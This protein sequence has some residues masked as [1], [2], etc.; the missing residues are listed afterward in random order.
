MVPYAVSLWWPVTTALTWSQKL[1]SQHFTSCCCCHCCCCNC[2]CCCRCCKG[3]RLSCFFHQQKAKRTGRFSPFWLT[4]HSRLQLDHQGVRATRW[5]LT[6]EVKHLRL[7]N[8][9]NEA[10]L[11]SRE[12]ISTPSRPRIGYLA[13]LLCCSSLISWL[14][15]VWKPWWSC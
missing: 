7:S 15:G 5:P 6:S 9:P 4:D 10:V 12:N 1:F 11:D 13:E 8:Q 14:T 2:S 3:I